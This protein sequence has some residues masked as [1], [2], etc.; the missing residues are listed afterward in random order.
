MLFLLALVLF[1]PPFFSES[2]LNSSK[3]QALHVVTVSYLALFQANA[4]R[5]MV[6]IEV[7]EGV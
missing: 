6:M 7:F 2:L 5:K 4:L 1:I 3:T